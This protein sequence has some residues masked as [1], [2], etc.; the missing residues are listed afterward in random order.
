MGVLKLFIGVGALVLG[1]FFH[2]L[3]NFTWYFMGVDLMG[4]V[5]MCMLIVFCRTWHSACGFV[6]LLW[7]VFGCVVP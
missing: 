1:A 4:Y 2:V 5:S 6:N 3:E 7:G